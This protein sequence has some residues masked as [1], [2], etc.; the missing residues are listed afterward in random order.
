[1][2]HTP[3][4]KGLGTFL[5][6][7]NSGWRGLTGQRGPE[8]EEDSS[9]D[10]VPVKNSNLNPT[11]DKIVDND[12]ISSPNPAFG[13]STSPQTGPVV[14]MTGNR[15]RPPAAAATKPKRAKKTN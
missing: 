1:M 8:V 7:L 4:N 5:S 9:V 3:S 14:T 6:G 15:K 10:S 12:N 11:N 13:A 2:T